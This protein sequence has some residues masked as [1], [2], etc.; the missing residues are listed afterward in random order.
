MSILSI[1]IKDEKR[2]LLKIISAVEDK[3]IGFLIESWID[4][5]VKSHKEQYKS[6]LSE[7]ELQGIMSISEP[8]FSEWDNDEDEVYNDL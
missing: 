4:D 1:R 8:A 3:T 2:R 6:V 5:Y 7:N